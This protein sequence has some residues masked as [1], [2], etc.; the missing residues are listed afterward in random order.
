MDLRPRAAGLGSSWSWPRPDAEDSANAAAA[1]SSTAKR[2]LVDRDTGAASSS[3]DYLQA[4]T[5][6][7][8]GEAFA[9]ATADTS[10]SAAEPQPDTRPP[11][12][13]HHQFK[14]RYR[15]RTCRICLE[16]VHPTFEDADEG[17]HE[18]M[19]PDGADDIAGGIGRIGERV[20]GVMASAIPSFLRPQ[21]RVRY[22][23]ED[24]RDGRLVCPCRCK[25]T[26]KYV[27]EGCLTA[28]RH[29]QPLSGRNYWKCPTC[30]FEYHFQRL[31]WG[32]WISNRVTRALL[33][34]LAFVLAIFLLGFIADPL[35][36]LW[37]D[38]AG[39]IVDTFNE[40]G[41][42]DAGDDILENLAGILYPHNAEDGDAGGAAG[43][44]E[45]FLKGFFS[46]GIVGVVK[47]FLAVSPFTWWN[48][49]GR[50][51]RRAG[52]RARIEGFGWM[53]VLVGA[54]TFLGVCFDSRIAMPLF[55][56]KT[57]Y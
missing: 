7:G 51:R 17:L 32:R 14:R 53:F 42:T 29:A 48:I 23:S 57:P 8:S 41:D 43:W 22:I 27:H 24:P 10:G 52:G 15:S 39:M 11:A 19:A 45:H 44:I 56:Q 18:E 16:V 9:T 40:L 5:R 13:P 33:T 49:R 50:V 12:D 26:Q 4:S 20:A 31:R 36:D 55:F 38:P 54:F 21:P 30:G 34:L 47:T 2:P 35:I 28:W 3:H 37:L 1:G 6:V 25:G 46:L